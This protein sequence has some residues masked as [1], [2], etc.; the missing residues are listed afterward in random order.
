M[1][2]GP[3]MCGDLYCMSCGPAQGNSK[4]PQCGTWSEDG[5]CQNPRQCELD[6][7]AEAE[8]EAHHY[9]ISTLAE[10]DAAVRGVS[11]FED[12]QFN[13]SEKGKLTRADLQREV[14]SMIASILKPPRSSRL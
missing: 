7:A 6:N 8:A 11:V 9:L 10:L 5:P 4:C 1:G 14:D 12:D 13:W 3:C 2:F